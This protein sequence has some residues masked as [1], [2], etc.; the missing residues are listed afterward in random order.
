MANACTKIPIHIVFPV[1]GKSFSKEQVELL[2]HC[3][4]P[5]TQRYLF[6]A[7]DPEQMAP[8]ELIAILCLCAL[9]PN[10]LVG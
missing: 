8:T 1:N 7:V 9:V 6:Q 2:K 3:N 5:H 4:V 10:Q